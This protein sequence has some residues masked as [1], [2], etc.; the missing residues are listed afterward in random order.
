M[1]A[2]KDR[3][4]VGVSGGPDSVALLHALVDIAPAY[5]LE[6]AVAHVHHGLRGADADCDAAFV[7][8]LA[9]G[10]GLPHY[11][12]AADV[13]KLRRKRRISVEEAARDVRYAFFNQT[14]RAQRYHRIAVGHTAD[15]NAESVLMNLLRGTGARG[16]SG[17]RPIR[18]NIIRP[19]I[20]VAR[21]Q[22]LS[23][24]NAA[25]RPYVSDASNADPSILRNRIRH[26]LMPMIARSYQPRI[27]ECLCRLA[28]ISR[29][30]DAWMSAVSRQLL[31]AAVIAVEPGR[32]VLSVDRICRWHPAAAARVLRHA[33]AGLKT[34]LRRV[35]HAHMAAV[36]RLITAG[37]TTGLVYLPD[38]IRVE[39]CYDRLVLRIEDPMQDA[40]PAV[41]DF[42][43]AIDGPG[44]LWIPEIG[45]YM[46]LEA[47]DRMQAGDIAGA[48]HCTA[49]F[50]M[51]M[52]EFPMTIRNVRPGDRFRP[53]GMTGHQKISDYFVNNKVP[54]SERRRI[55]VL[56]SG[57]RVIWLAG[58]RIDESA[59]ILYATRRVLKAQLI[60]P[61]NAS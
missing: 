26:Q 46:T 54:R 58:H 3:V 19:L 50:D 25:D 17:I 5:A 18:G 57:N 52:I 20:R 14:A 55:P 4:L 41:H 59:K 31:D 21:S 34:N 28:D 1:L 39:R 16:L 29:Q 9:V 56:V 53:L 11:S 40:R 32:W 33:V 10:L 35:A 30:E 44:S 12:I 36:L 13:Q 8:R 51:R 45:A 22:V 37:P 43:Y 60:L 27:R 6:L 15:D 48:G 47:F 24:L 7:A 42:E 49:F 23:Y 61:A 2:P 38:G